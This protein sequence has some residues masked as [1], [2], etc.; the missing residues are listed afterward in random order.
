M[1]ITGFGSE[2]KEKVCELVSFYFVINENLFSTE[3]KSTRKIELLGANV[4]SWD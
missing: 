3:W 4:S 2:E 1:I